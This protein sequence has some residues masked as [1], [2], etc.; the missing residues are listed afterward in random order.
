M[1]HRS[2]QQQVLNPDFAS[3][4]MV[5]TSE[6]HHP[7]YIACLAAIVCIAALFLPTEGELALKVTTVKYMIVLFIQ[8]LSLTKL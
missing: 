2:S 4:P 6:S 5:A 3:V 8:R 7:N 1:P